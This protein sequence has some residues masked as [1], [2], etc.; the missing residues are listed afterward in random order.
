M[1]LSPLLPM[2]AP[3]PDGRGPAM[4]GMEPDYARSYAH[5]PRLAD[6]VVNYRR[7]EWKQMYSSLDAKQR[8]TPDDLDV[9]RLQADVYLVNGAFQEAVSQL[10]Q[11]LRRKPDD[12]H[13]LAITALVQRFMGEDD[14]AECRM[15]HL[16]QRSPA[17]ADDLRHF[18]RTTDADQYAT[19]RPEPHPDADPDV[20]AVFG[21]SPNP[22]GTP[23]PGLL[24]RM[25]KAEEM[26]ARFPAARIVVSGAAIRGPEPEAGFMRDL[27]VRQGVD[28]SRILTD[29]RARDTVG[30][31]IGIVAACREYGLHDVLAVSAL[32]HLP[33][34]VTTLKALARRYRWTMTVDAAGSG[35]NAEPSRQ[36]RERRYTYVTAARAA[37]LFERD[38]FAKYAEH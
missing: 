9:Y 8:A 20:I 32:S 28:P 23:S 18:I 19:F 7:W 2:P 27:L 36:V 33:R 26:A 16:R 31:A 3:K 13:A 25:T 5:N 38:D 35:E 12:I 22:D 1:K 30:N 15:S 10:D 34:A 29:D 11:V 14:D 17:A 4:D 37:G 6:E 24:L 21:Q